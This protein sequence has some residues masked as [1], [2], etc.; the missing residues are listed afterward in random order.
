M[1]NLCQQILVEISGIKQVQAQEVKHRQDSEA[2]IQ[3]N[4]DLIN[5]SLLTNAIP[6]APEKSMDEHELRNMFKLPINDRAQVGVFNTFLST[7][8]EYKENLVSTLTLQSFN[9]F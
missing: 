3:T 6:P 9:Q 1:E 2:R 4:L 7:Y 8:P 5:Q